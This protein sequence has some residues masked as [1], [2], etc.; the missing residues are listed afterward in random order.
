[1]G[2]G[3]ELLKIEKYCSNTTEYRAGKFGCDKKLSR[4]PPPSPSADDMYNDRFLS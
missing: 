3:G 1:M 2:G 4:L